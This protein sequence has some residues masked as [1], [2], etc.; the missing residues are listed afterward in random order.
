MSSNILNTR[1]VETGDVWREMDLK[2][3][4]LEVLLLSDTILG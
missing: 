3:Q 2:K 1:A 4:L